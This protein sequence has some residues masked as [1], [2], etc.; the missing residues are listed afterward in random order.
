MVEPRVV[1][2]LNQGA[3]YQSA[4]DWRQVSNGLALVGGQSIV[5]LVRLCGSPTVV[6]WSKG[7]CNVR[8]KIAGGSAGEM[9]EVYCSREIA[10]GF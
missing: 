2:G 1:Q 9:L 7:M 5:C 4:K 10:V 6:V 3:L 8:A